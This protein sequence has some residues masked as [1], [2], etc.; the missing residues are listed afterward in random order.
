MNM[1]SVQQIAILGGGQLARMLVQAGVPLGLGFKVIDKSVDVC[2]AAIAPAVA[3]DWD[4][5]AEVREAVAG[6]DAVTFD[7]ENVPATSAA[8]LAETTAVR[9]GANALATAQDRLDEK[10]LFE[11][12]GL[13]VAAHMA[14][15]DHAA[16][17]RALD[18]IGTPAILKTRRF[19]YDGKGQFRLHG[20]A[21]ADAAWRALGSAAGEHGLILEAMVPFERE[22]SILAV[23]GQDGEFRSWPLV[24][25]VHVDGILSLSLAPARV[26][27]AV[28]QAAHAHARSIAEALDYVGVFAVELFDLGDRLLGNEMAPR[29]HNSGHWSIEGAVTSQFENHVRAVAGLPLGSTALRGTSLM[30]NFIGEMPD[31]TTLLRHPDVHLHDYGKSPRPGRKL[32]HATLCADDHDALFQRAR[33]LV[34]DLGCPDRLAGL[35]KEGSRA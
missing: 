33:A 17:D 9:P 19:G 32:G 8:M 7:W 18:A 16:L 27:A 29:V 28:Q 35:L 2:A 10:A 21:D 1:P 20:S 30:L 31:R 34:E 25:N 12:C 23:R 22:L 11:S 5:D 26:E 24:Q 13:P 6:A 15:D 14:V 3:V 4:D